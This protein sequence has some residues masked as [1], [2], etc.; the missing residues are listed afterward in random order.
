MNKAYSKIFTCLTLATAIN[1]FA[2]NVNL[3][4]IQAK[5]ESQINLIDT[6]YQTTQVSNKSFF[7]Q[8]NVE[9]IQQGNKIKISNL[10]V[11]PGNMPS[12]D[13]ATLIP[14]K[15][16]LDQLI[17]QSQKAI[18]EVPENS[19]IALFLSFTTLDK[20]T[21]L[22]Y[23]KQ[24]VKY[25]IPIVL[26]GFINNSF[27]ETGTYIKVIREQF[28]ELTILIDPPAYEKYDITVIP[29]LVV[30]KSAA[31]PIKDGCNSPGDYVKVYGEISIAGMLDYVRFNSKNPAL[32]IAA[33]NS[34]NGIRAK[35]YFKSE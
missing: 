26:R 28:P 1:S 24:A 17:N 6:N 11:I 12:I 23:A 14:N 27:K 35:R 29:A 22:M 25:N 13:L 15:L 30:S 16:Q 32:V 33:N 3:S 8:S 9:S 31:N 20:D 2:A 19:N 34:I 10:K 21:V 7:A 18:S 4:N 5:N